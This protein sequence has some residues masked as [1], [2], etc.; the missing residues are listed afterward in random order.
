MSP[1]HSHIICACKND[2]TSPRQSPTLPS[3]LPKISKTC[4]L[5]I[6]FRFLVFVTNVLKFYPF[7]NCAFVSPWIKIIIMIE[8]SHELKNFYAVEIRNPDLS[9]LRKH[10]PQPIAVKISWYRVKT[11]LRTAAAFQRPTL[12]HRFDRSS[13]H[14][15][16]SPIS[17]AKKS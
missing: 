8:T 12:Q 7:Y 3:M 1:N 11:S 14:R 10:I 13:S 15:P 4:S 2:V 9:L 16:Y 5:Q 17:W 6:I